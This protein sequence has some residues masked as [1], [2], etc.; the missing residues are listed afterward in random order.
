MRAADRTLRRP[1]PSPSSL[2][3]SVAMTGDAARLRADGRGRGGME[4]RGKDADGAPGRGRGCGGQARGE[5]TLGGGARAEALVPGVGEG[6]CCSQEQNRRAGARVSGGCGGRAGRSASCAPRG[7]PTT[8]PQAV[9]LSQE[10]PS[11]FQK[12]LQFGRGR[13]RRRPAS[14]RPAPQEQVWPAGG[15][16]RGCGAAMC[17]LAALAGRL[18]SGGRAP[19]AST[20][21]LVL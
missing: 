14:P 10:T 13:L 8:P 5:G 20:L 9:S 12:D 16:G 11:P 21:S 15:R 2:S 17:R 1:P 18:G 7:R 6:G 3:W 4:R 19:A